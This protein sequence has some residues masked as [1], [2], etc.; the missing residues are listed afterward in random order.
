MPRLMAG[1]FCFCGDVGRGIDAGVGEDAGCG[2][3]GSVGGVLFVV[4]GDAGE[5][6][7]VEDASF[8]WFALVVEVVEVDQEF[9]E[10]VQACSGLGVGVGEVVEPGGDL[11]EAGADA[12]LLAR[13][14]V[15]GDRVGVVS[16]VEFEAFGLELVALGGQE[17]AFV[18]AG[19]FELVEHVVEDLPDV[20]SL[21]LGQGVALVGAFD[22]GFGAFGEDR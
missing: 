6:G 12:V 17:L 11:V 21:G 2:L 9:S 20:L 14:E 10:L 18:L 3:L 4:D 15:E 7:A 19:S 8:G 16:L 5:Q 22:L 13:E 1:Q